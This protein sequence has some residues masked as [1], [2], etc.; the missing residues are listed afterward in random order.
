MFE[1]VLRCSRKVVLGGTVCA[2]LSACQ[3]RPQAEPD[4]GPPQQVVTGSKFTVLAPLNFSA[5][6]SELLFQNEQLVTA[7]QLS[8]DMPYCRLAPDAG[9][10]QTIAPGSLPVRSV[11]YDER[12]SGGT[13]G[14]VSVTRIALSAA[15]NSPGYVLSCGWPA[16]ATSRGFVTAQQIYNA[17]GGQLFSMD[18]LR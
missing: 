16:R 13:S 11:D 10:P 1:P 7:A 17:I 5:G 6:R 12:E 9:A 8:Q 3:H 14:M 18:T 15:A 2:M 4:P